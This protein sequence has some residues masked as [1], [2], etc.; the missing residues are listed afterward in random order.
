M[1]AI[2]ITTI[3]ELYEVKN[4]MNVVIEGQ[5]YRE[6][7]SVEETEIWARKYYS[8]LLDLP[9]ENEFHKMISYYTGGYYKW[10]NKLLRD[11]LPVDSDQFRKIDSADIRDDVKEIQKIIE[12]LCK[13]SLPENII[14]YRFTHKKVIRSL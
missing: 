2:I 8:D 14:V 10:Y 9:K 7:D 1:S 3:K 12:V 6:F 4:K 13:Y 5:A 11:Y